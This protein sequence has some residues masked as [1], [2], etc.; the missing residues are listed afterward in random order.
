MNQSRLFDSIAHQP[1]SDTSR[2]AARG[3]APIL[4]KLQSR[5]FN[6]LESRGDQGATDEEIQRALGMNPSTQRPRRI[7]LQKQGLVADSGIRRKTASGRMAGVWV[8]VER[9]RPVH[10][11]VGVAGP[12]CAVC[13]ATLSGAQ[14][15]FCSDRCR[16]TWHG[17][18]RRSC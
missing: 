12:L 7:E 3:V 15:L 9:S 14:K 16:M 8:A 11:R 6:W 13:P 17:N 2:D 10:G 18:K 5:V 4:N 1:H